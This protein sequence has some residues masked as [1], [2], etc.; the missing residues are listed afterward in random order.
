MALAKHRV[1]KNY[2][3]SRSKA[4]AIIKRIKRKEQMAKKKSEA[5]E[6]KGKRSKG[7][8]IPPEKYFMLSNGTAIRSIEELAVLLDN[9]SDEDFSSHVNS[10]KND[11]ASWINDVFGEKELAES[12]KPLTDKKESQ[13]ALLKHAVSKK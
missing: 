7:A 4:H 1:V 2:V 8:G 3:K 9:I 12:L 6:R 13:I 11:F 5:K 10:E